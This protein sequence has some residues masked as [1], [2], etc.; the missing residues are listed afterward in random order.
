MGSGRWVVVNGG[1]SLEGILE[2]WGWVVGVVRF[3]F[4]K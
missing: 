4:L 1:K 3:L 2:G